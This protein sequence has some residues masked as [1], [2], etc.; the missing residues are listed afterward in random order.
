MLG[1]G[2]IVLGRSVA[3]SDVGDAFLR[4]VLGEDGDPPSLRDVEKEYVSKVLEHVGWNK[5]R[6]AK[7]LGVSVPTVQ[8]KIQDY[9][10]G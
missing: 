10:I 8:K 2:S 3:S 6:A 1:L 9:G 4:V 5:T 7:L